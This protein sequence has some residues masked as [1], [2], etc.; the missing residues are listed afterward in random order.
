MHATLTTRPRAA[1]NAFLAHTGVPLAP[2]PMFATV[3]GPALASYL[4]EDDSEPGLAGFADID[5]DE[6]L[7]ARCA[8]L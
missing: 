3:P 4:D 2:L 7:A 6:I 5:L 8:C 1:P